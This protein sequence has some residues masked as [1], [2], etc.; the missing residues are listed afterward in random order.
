MKQSSQKIKQVLERI[1]LE[2]QTPEYLKSDPIEFPH[3]YSD[4]QDREISGFISALFSYGN[5]A[6]IKEHLKRLFALCGNS[7]YQ[8]LLKE[9]LKYVRNKL[10]PYRFQKPADTYLFLRTIQNKLRKTKDHT[11][12]SLFSIP[13]E[14][15]FKL[16]AKDQKS[17]AEGGT[18]RRRI[19]AFQLRF[20]E[21]SKRIDEKQTEA[22]GYKFL[23]GQGIK[24]TS[25]KRYSMYLRWMVRKEYPDFGIYSTIS[26]SELQ[27]P[28][29]IHIQ[30][31]ASVLRIGSRQTPDWK[32]AEEITDFFREIFPDDPVRGDF[33]LSR[34]GILKKCKSAYDVE[35]CETCR[36]NT[37]CKVYENKSLSTN[38]TL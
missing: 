5:V 36:I 12:E 10:K 37:I 18:L 22:Y 20:L 29:D 38:I 31:I 3:S 24:T 25:L 7:P 28:L 35:L 16:S 26:P 34:L 1:F 32:K 6:S 21:E 13:Q 27:F 14:G 9:D 17:F 15:E 4:A 2:Y 33:A 19:L 23:I 30:R 8:F 11:L